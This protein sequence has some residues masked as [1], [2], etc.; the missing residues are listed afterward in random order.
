MII[1]GKSF[2]VT[3]G[4]FDVDPALYGDSTRHATVALKENRT[5][6]ELAFLQAALAR[7]TPVLGICGG[8]QLLAVLLGG[9]LIQHIPDQV[10]GALA[11]ELNQPLSAIANY[12]KGGRRLLE[13]ERPDIPRAAEAMKAKIMVKIERLESRLL[14]SD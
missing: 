4:A 12:L 10:P 8:Q 1:E 7:D 11:H 3:G 14:G 13:R 5:L 2:I 9:T 6:A